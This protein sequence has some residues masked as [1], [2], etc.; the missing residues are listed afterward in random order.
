[1]GCDLRSLNRR[2]ALIQLNY[3]DFVQIKKILRNVLMILNE[4]GNMITMTNI[5]VKN[6]IQKR[7]AA[8]LNGLI[9]MLLF[10]LSF[11]FVKSVV[12]RIK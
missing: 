7:F 12:A 10:I 9:L 1:M 4:S 2:L 11:I 5:S 3:R 8:T 6:L